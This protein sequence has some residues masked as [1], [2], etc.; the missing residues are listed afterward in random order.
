MQP[1]S[2]PVQLLGLSEQVAEWLRDQILSGRLHDGDRIIERDV[3]AQLAVSRGPIRD[4][5]RQLQTEGLVH[6]LPRRG[7]RVATLTRKDAIE[8]IAIR[9][10]LEPVAVRFLL[11]RHDRSLLDPLQDCLTRI[12]QASRKRDWSA[13]VTLDMEFHE[14]VFRQAGS[15]WLERVW[16]GLRIPLLQTFRLH[17]QFYDSGADVLRSH[18][19]LLDQLASGDLQAAEEATRAHAVDLRDQLLEHMRQLETTPADLKE[20]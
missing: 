6:W 1:A 19:R 16:E 12:E 15:A 3:A 13:L 4:A 20:Q 17:R 2:G 18:Q 14:L 7:A 8:V 9:Q 5:L 11:D 10:A